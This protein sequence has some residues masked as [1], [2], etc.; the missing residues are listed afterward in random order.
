MMLSRLFRTGASAT[1]CSGVAGADR[2]AG[3]DRWR[4]PSRP[5]LG[6]LCRAYGRFRIRPASFNPRDDAGDEIEF[7]GPYAKAKIG[8]RQALVVD[9]FIFLH[10]ATKVAGASRCRRPRPCI[11]SVSMICRPRRLQRCGSVLRRSDAAPARV[12]CATDA[13]CRQPGRGRAVAIQR[14]VIRSKQGWPSG[15]RAPVDLYI[16]TT[17]IRLSPNAWMTWSLPSIRRGTKGRHL[18]AGRLRV[19]GRALLPRLMSTTSSR[20]RHQRADGNRCVSGQRKA[21]Y[22]DSSA[23]R[24]RCSESLDVLGVM[25]EATR[26]VDF[27]PSCDQPAMRLCQH[28]GRQPAHRSRREQNWRWVVRCKKYWGYPVPRRISVFEPVPYFP[29]RPN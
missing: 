29:A 23:L 19:G 18:G 2:L 8:R 7:T 28:G 4:I 1:R 16:E 5:A 25:E 14:S 12:C 20:V 3:G 17:S 9:E 21:W 26:Y 13:G 27:G 11:S 15:E 10:G 22:S 6:A 24:V